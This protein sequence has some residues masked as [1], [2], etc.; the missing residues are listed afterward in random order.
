MSTQT[1]NAMS[2]DKQNQTGGEG[3]EETTVETTEETTTEEVAEESDEFT[4]EESEETT[5]S[6][7]ESDS[8]APLKVDFKGKNEELRKKLA[9]EAFKQREN[10]RETKSDDTDDVSDDDDRPLTR[11]ELQKLLDER[12]QKTQRQNSVKEAM[13][14]ARSLTDSDDEAEYATTLWEH[15]TLPFDT[16]EEQMRFII[17]GLNAE[18]LLAQ[19]KELVRAVQSKTLARKN[20][21]VTSRDATG[22]GIPKIDPQVKQALENTGFKFVPAKK[23]WEK[24]LA[25]GKKMYNDGKG[26]KWFE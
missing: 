12:E 18:R 8:K 6:G 26:K 15:V 16:M 25:N 24:T 23:A 21:A 19:K 10:K 13:T 20:T 14:I 5:E 7:E 17:G 3:V 4:T 1:I 22:G 2:M 11:A 9:A